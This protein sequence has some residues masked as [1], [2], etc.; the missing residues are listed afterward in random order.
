MHSIIFQFGKIRLANHRTV[1]DDVA[2][3]NDSE[4]DVEPIDEENRGLILRPLSEKVCAK[5]YFLDREI[6][7][8]IN[9]HVHNLI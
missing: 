7:L 5:E 9:H 3:A 2:D 8:I 4:D 1:P 6:C